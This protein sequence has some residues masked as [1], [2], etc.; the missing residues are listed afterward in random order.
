M[1]RPRGDH[2][3]RLFQGDRLAL[4]HP[5]GEEMGVDG[6][7]EHLAYMGAGIGERHG[8]LGVAHQLEKTV[9]ILDQKVLDEE[10][11]QVMLQ[12]DVDHRLDRVHP[13]PAGL[14][15][16]GGVGRIERL[17]DSHAVEVRS[18]GFR[19]EGPAIVAV[20]GGVNQSAAHFGVA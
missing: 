16:D 15:G 4:A 1:R 10:G 2:L 18:G 13:T 8:G 12:G 7:I 19:P 6:G 14:F 20:M 5:I 17:Q 9:V 11:V 3:D